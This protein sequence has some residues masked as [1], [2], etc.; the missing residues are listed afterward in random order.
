MD[1]QESFSNRLS[2][3]LP[4]INWL[5]DYKKQWLSSDLIAGTTLAAFTIPEAIAYSDL[6][7]MP[8][9]AGLYA[10]IAAPILYTLFGASRQLAVGPTSAVSILVAAALG[11]LTV[12]SPA[13]YA[14]LAGMTAIMVGLIAVVAYLLKL[15]VLMNFISESVL[16]GFSSGAALY[17]A[18]TQLGK[19]FGIHGGHGEFIERISHLIQHI[20]EANLWALALGILALAIL[21]SGEHLVPRLP[22]TLIIV[23]G[24]IGLMNVIDPKAHG[25]SIIGSIPSGLPDISLPT[26]S[27]ADVRQ[28]L[29]GAFA[30]FV[31]AYV[32]GMSMART[33]ASKHGY[34][35]DPN[36]ELL[37]L[38]F[39]SIGAGFTQSY[40][41]AG[42]LSR[43]ALN[44]KAGAKTQLAG[45]F[46]ALLIVLV[47]LF[48]TGIFSKL[49][50]PVL[51]AVVLM[52][53][54]GL[55]KWKRLFKLFELS[56]AEFATALAAFIGVLGLGILD[57]VVIGALLSLLLVIW[58]TSQSNIS[59][60]GRVPGQAQFTSMHEN[61]ESMPVPGMIIMSADSSIF[62]ANAESIKGRIME[63]VRE[64][65]KPIHAVVLDIALTG[66]LDL[67]GAEMLAELHQELGKM[68]IS[69]RLSRVQESARKM[70]DRMGITAQIGEEHFHA[71]P[72]LAVAEYLA[73]EGLS[74]RMTS[75]ILP[76]MVRY[77]LNMVRERAGL[78][79]GEEQI[80]LDEIRAK[81]EE[82][83]IDLENIP[84]AAP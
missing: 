74:H 4:I 77:V 26:V 1:R 52:A 64:G 13:Q 51:A 38:G 34:K 15:G 43:S 28:V 70:L 16:V 33:F 65:G 72:L 17:I 41:V 42:S 78:V 39:S 73:E 46:S 63:L 67:A 44:D 14:A 7:G 58:R 21:M 55:F 71:S 25:I 66:H 9:Q 76:D 69:L 29:R 31:L 36:E 30:I 37:A 24:S 75:D 62:Y 68:G 56:P 5:P 83:L 45:G 57:G 19:F 40:P 18:S 82:V 2:N 10:C 32:E 47:V 50:E 12:H 59:L 6:A 48:L 81:L 60:L 22:W 8:P 54:R 49:P 27:F 3:W 79:T 23:L 11:G 35:V 84:G 80:R 61:P 20:G 53:V